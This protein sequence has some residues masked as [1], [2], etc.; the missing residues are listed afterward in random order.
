MPPNEPEITRPEDFGQ[1]AMRHLT[2]WQIKNPDAANP[3]NL[4][5]TSPR[6][7][8][9]NRLRHAFLDGVDAGMSIA[10]VIVKRQ[11]WPRRRLVVGR[12]K[13]MMRGGR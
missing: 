11:S 8:L 13:G 3:N 5:T 1:M 12:G 6:T 10:E 4:G 9:E 7:Y 2:G